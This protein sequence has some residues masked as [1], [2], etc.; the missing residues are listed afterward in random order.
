M[1]KLM[2]GFTNMIETSYEVALI[3]LAVLAVRCVLEWI[4]VPRKYICLLWII[5]FLRMIVPFQM[6]SEFSLMPEEPPAVIIEMKET[7][8]TFEKTGIRDM[9]SSEVT[10]YGE[11][12]SNRAES[13]TMP[14]VQGTDETVGNSDKFSKW[15]LPVTAVIWLAGISV[16]LLYSIVSYVRFRYRL[17]TAVRMNEDENI[18]LAD[19]IDSPFVL[20][21][22]KSVIYIPSD[23]KESMKEYVIAHEKEH[24]RRKDP[25][26]KVIAYGISLV[27]WMN[28]FTWAAYYFLGRDMEIACD[29]AV[30]Q[31]QDA[32]YRKEYAHTLLFLS[33]GKVNF[34]GVPL[35]FAEGDPKDRVEKIATYKKPAFWAAAVGIVCVAVLAVGCLSN[36]KN[37]DGTGNTASSDKE[38]NKLFKEKGTFAKAAKVNL[39]ASTGTGGSKLYYVDE[40]IIIFGG[41]YGV[42]VFSKEEAKIVASVDLMELGWEEAC[43]VKVSADGKYIYFAPEAEDVSYVYDWKT[44]KIHPLKEAWENLDIF[45][46]FLDY[47]MGSSFMENGEKVYFQL[48]EP[49]SQMIGDLMYREYRLE[50]ETGDVIEDQYRHLFLEG[51]YKDLQAFEPEDLVP[52]V[53]VEMVI[54]GEV[55]TIIDERTLAWI[56]EHFVEAE[57]IKGGSGCPFY[58][59]MYVTRKDGIVGVIYPAE[60][61]CSAFRTENGNYYDYTPG[62]EDNSEFWSHFEGWL[63]GIYPDTYGRLKEEQ[64]GNSLEEEAKYVDGSWIFKGKSYRYRLEVTGRWENA[65]KDVTYVVVTNK[66]DITFEELFPLSGLSSD[67]DAKWEVE[68]DTALIRIEMNKE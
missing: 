24:I 62:Y 3:V 54:Q 19:N 8:D 7:A 29:E 21:G 2:I 38:E 12:L 68:R 27:H 31:N 46:Y 1:D 57:T 45:D 40:E 32:K 33:V 56:E 58:H 36:P 59:P 63:E 42:F 35:A 20:C 6:E 4:R 43:E 49:Q 44:I 53:K 15:I 67:L 25:V 10:A 37:Q 55:R 51:R 17:S 16:M 28:P 22:R 30:I 47:G 14:M 11:A 18:Y 9:I 65:E 50:E 61:S 60:D 5:P 41:Y 39:K 52:I 48:K 23:M 13:E 34:N 64:K 66:K 26:V